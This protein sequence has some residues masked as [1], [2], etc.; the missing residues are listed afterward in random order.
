MSN[1]PEERL[2]RRNFMI[3]SI[4]TAGASAALAVNAGTANAQG[5]A[6]PSADAASGTI[7]TGDV[8]RGKKVVSALNVN[9]LE[10]GKKHLLYFQGVQ[11]PTG[12]CVG[13]GRKG[14]KARQADH[15]GQWCAWRRDELGAYRGD[16][17]EPTRAGRDVRHGD[18]GHGRL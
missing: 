9:D 16:R 10:P 3:A 13:D 2:D 17:D 18:G 11:M 7:Y 1:R 15:S 6:T 4:A 8:V 12:Q 5:V 14:G